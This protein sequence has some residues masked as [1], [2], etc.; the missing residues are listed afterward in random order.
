MDS[1][2]AAGLGSGLLPWIAH[3]LRDSRY[4]WADPFLWASAATAFAGLASG[5]ALRALVPSRRAPASSSRRRS[6]RFARAIAFL[7]LGILAAA[8]LLVLADKGA[9][10]DALAPGGGLLP[11]AAA[12][13]ALGLLAGFSPLG[14]GLPL[15]GLCLVVLVLV[16]LALAGWL[17]FRQPAASPSGPAFEIARLL[18]YEAGAASFRGQI[19]LPERDSVPVAQEAALASGSAGLMAETLALKGPLRLAARIAMPRARSAAFATTRLYRVSGLYGERGTSQ[20]F[21]APRNAGLLDAVLPLGAAEG[22]A[23]SS[24][25]LFGLALRLRVSSPAVP[26]VALQPVSFRLAEDGSSIAVK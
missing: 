15:S 5:Q 24:A 7:S 26:L 20:D 19:E 18:P 11:C 1:S 12:F 9:L 16:R 13:S 22:P 8:T 4:L 3:Y 17:P 14:L 25:G 6:R 23:S 21:P 10:A 2:A